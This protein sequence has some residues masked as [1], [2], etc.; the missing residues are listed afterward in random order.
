MGFFDWLLG[1]PKQLQTESR[2]TQQIATETPAAPQVQTARVTMNG[3]P[4]T[5]RS[6]EDNLKRWRESGKAR[7]WVEARNG[8]WNHDDWVALLDSLK[9]SEFWP[10]NPEAIGH[11]LEELKNARQTVANG[12]VG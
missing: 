3:T 12:Q 5:P 10:M 8:H 4:A 1:K 7:A 6:A 9:A 11:T 2:T